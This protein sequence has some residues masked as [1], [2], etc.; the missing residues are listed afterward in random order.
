MTRY[1]TRLIDEH[2]FYSP[3]EL[4]FE[5]DQTFWGVYPMHDIN[6][7]RYCVLLTRVRSGARREVLRM[8][9]PWS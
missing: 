7:Q 1:P 3:E 4:V 9:D 5:I 2:K 6:V 8:Q